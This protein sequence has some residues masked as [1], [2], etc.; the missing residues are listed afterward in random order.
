MNTTTTNKTIKLPNALTIALGQ[1]YLTRALATPHKIGATWNG[2]NS[3]VTFSEARPWD[4]EGALKRVSDSLPKGW[5]YQASAGT[6]WIF[7]KG[8]KKTHY[9]IHDKLWPVA[10]IR[11]NRA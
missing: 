11:L 3:T 4:K 8:N 9:F 2:N 6:F 10:E 7:K 5:G 1:Y